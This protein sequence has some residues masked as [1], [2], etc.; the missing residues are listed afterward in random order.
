MYL[1]KGTK[2][3]PGFKGFCVKEGVVEALKGKFTFPKW[4]VPW[5]N[6]PQGEFL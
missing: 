4:P 6:G 1:H 5:G 2:A 3:I